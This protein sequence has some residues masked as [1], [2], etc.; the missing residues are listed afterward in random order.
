MSTQVQFVHPSIAEIPERELVGRLLADPYWSF[1]LFNIKGIPKD[2]VVRR[3]VDL[4]GAPGDFK[5]DVDIL[6]CDPARPDQAVAH[7]VKRIKFGARLVERGWPNTLQEYEEA[8]RQA[9]LLARIGF[10]QVYLY[11][12]MV[13]DAR[14][15]HLGKVSYAG[16]TTKQRA[17]IH[18]RVSTVGLENRVGLFQL[19]FVQPMDY[20]PLA[21]ATYGGDFRRHAEPVA[22][23]EELTEWVR[24]QIA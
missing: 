8:V 17:M 11:V 9:N 22:Q 15:H 20:A 16:L 13:V 5:G 7:Q 3:D 4:T 18:S 19:E 6:L 23:P 21:T 1:R 10:S 24:Q 12:L 2:P 14:E